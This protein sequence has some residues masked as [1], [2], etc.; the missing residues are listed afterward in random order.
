MIGSGTRG[1][2]N[3]RNFRNLDPLRLGGSLFASECFQG[4][5]FIRELF[6]DFPVLV[7]SVLGFVDPQVVFSWS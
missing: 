4:D 2:E 3:R 6:K 1:K 7:G 5:F